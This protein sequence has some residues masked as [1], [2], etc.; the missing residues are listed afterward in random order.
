VSLSSSF[1]RRWPRPAIGW[2]L[3]QH[4]RVDPDWVREYVDSLGDRLSGL[5][6]RE[7]TKHL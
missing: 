4:A 5:P 3:R 1:G 6:R 7:A 2:A